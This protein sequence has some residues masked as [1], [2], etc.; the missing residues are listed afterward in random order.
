MALNPTVMQAVEKLDYRVT[1]GDVATSAGL[2][3]NLAERELLALA[4]EAGGHLQV[5]DTGDIV[6]QFPKQFRAI[7]RNKYFR[8]QLQE[9][10]EKVWRILFYLI[11]ISFGIIL[12]L[13][14]FIIFASIFILLTMMNKDSNSN[15]SS[16]SRGGGMIFF[17]RMFWGPDIFWFFNPNYGR[18]QRQRRQKAVDS[19]SSE[20][21][22]NFLESVFSFLFGDGNPN[23]N[24]EERRWQAIAA[25]IQNNQGA[26]VAEQIAPYLDDLGTGYG[27][28]YEDYMLP[29]LTRFNGRPEV[30]PEGQIVYHFP[31][32]QTTVQQRNAQSVPAYLRELT[33]K[34]SE[35]S[36]NQL[37]LAAGL[38][39]VNIGGGIFLGYLLQDGAIAAQIGG[40]VAFTA[41]IYWLLI[42]YGVAFLSVPLIRYLWLKGRNRK[43][44]VRNEARQEQAIALNQPSDELQKK[45]AY[46]QQFAA[47]NIIGS[48]DIAYTTETDLI[49]Q[50]SQNSAKLD[51]EWRKRL[52]G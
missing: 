46:A 23:A 22:M 37:S 49:E 52:E 45:L 51:A 12:I 39:V 16:R 47:Q 36:S 40:L 10:W 18:Y 42:G 5:A 1:V 50:E 26:V 19:S 21:S 38:G 17:P 7:L 13:S 20:E 43:V 8:I 4:S 6:Y 30:S 28:E 25:I 44:E 27:K 48:G 24:L 32:L 34:F 14:I 29:V 3:V 35:A 33:W 41:S 15:R 31:E 11:R 2:Q 9:W